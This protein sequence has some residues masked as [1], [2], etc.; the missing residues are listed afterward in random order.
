MFFTAPRHLG[1]SDS[2]TTVSQQ[3]AQAGA[4]P[5]ATDKGK[6]VQHSEEQVH[7]LEQPEAMAD[8]PAITD[9]Q[10]QGQ[11]PPIQEKAAEIRVLQ[12]PANEER[13]KKRDRQEETPLGTSTDQPGEKR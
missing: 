9:E 13:T 2:S 12:T 7:N 1:E 5:A 10:S 8:R 6:E 4:Q 11:G 3:P